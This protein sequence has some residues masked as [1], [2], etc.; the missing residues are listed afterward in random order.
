MRSVHGV[1]P[2]CRQRRWLGGPGRVC[3]STIAIVVA[4]SAAS[5]TVQACKLD[6]RS[7]AAGATHPWRAAAAAAAAAGRRGLGWGPD[8]REA[9]P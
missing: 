6:L 1:A 2:R 3:A 7:A 9:A 4:A 5:A 8:A